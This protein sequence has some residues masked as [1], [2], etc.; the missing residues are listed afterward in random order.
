MAKAQAINTSNRLEVIYSVGRSS[1][2]AMVRLRCVL[3]MLLSWAGAAGCLP[4][5]NLTQDPQYHFSSMAGRCF[6]TRHVM[7]LVKGNH[8][9]F[10]IVVLHTNEM[11]HSV[12]EFYNDST[13]NNRPHEEVVGVLSI[14]SRIQIEGIM[15]NPWT[16]AGATEYTVA[17]IIDGKFAGKSIRTGPLLHVDLNWQNWRADDRYLAPCDKKDD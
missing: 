7:F 16:T 12:E 8:A 10:N 17:R 13:Y 14:G 15:G 9:D 1:R 6:V 2:E 11:P 3:I 5:Q 4:Q